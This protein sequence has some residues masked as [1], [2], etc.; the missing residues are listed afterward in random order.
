MEQG[1][2][3][4]EAKGFDTAQ[5]V[6]LWEQ[7]TLSVSCLSLDTV[8]EHASIVKEIQQSN[9]AGSQQDPFP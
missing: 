7:S 2:L 5:P 4:Y 3:K 6:A 1:A 8:Q 9:A